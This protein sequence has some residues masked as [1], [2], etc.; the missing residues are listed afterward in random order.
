MRGPSACVHCAA[1]DVHVASEGHGASGLQE[2]TLYNL[3]SHLEVTAADLQVAY[4]LL[5][6]AEL[7]PSFM[8]SDLAGGHLGVNVDGLL[9]GEHS[10]DGSYV[11]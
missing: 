11:Y 10:F 9:S 6:G 8:E 7:D 4:V 5:V 3:Q 2:L 1:L